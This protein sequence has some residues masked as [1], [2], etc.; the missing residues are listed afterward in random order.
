MVLTSKDI[1][2]ERI[3]SGKWHIL[4]VN[5]GEDGFSYEVA[6]ISRDVFEVWWLP[7]NKDYI[8]RLRKQVRETGP[9]IQMC[10]KMLFPDKFKAILPSR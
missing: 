7:F 10:A 1:F 9:Y 3:R 4:A 6:L 5:E 2:E 8:I